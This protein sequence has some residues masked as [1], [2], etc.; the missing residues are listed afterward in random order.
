MAEKIVKVKKEKGLAR[1]WR[2]TIGEL[3]KVAWP[4]PREAWQLTKVVLLV[5]L[6]MGIVLGGLDF[7]FTRLI[8]LILG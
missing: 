1:W 7:L 2:E 8:G 6:A 5:M 4:T 3:H